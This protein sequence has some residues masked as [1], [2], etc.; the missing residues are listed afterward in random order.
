MKINIILALFL[1]YIQQISAQFVSVLEFPKGKKEVEIP[2]ELKNNFIVVNIIFNRILPLQ[3]IYDTGAEH[4]ILTQKELALLLG[5]PFERKINILG[6]DL[7]RELVAHIARR[8]PMQ[9]GDIKF[10]R[11]VLVFEE[12]YFEFDKYAGVQI[13]G[14]LGADVFHGYV[15]TLDY[16]R[17]KL[18]VTEGNAF[19]PPKSKH[20]EEVPFELIRNRPYLIAKITMPKDT[21]VEAK[22]LIDTGAALGLLLHLQTDKRFELPQKVITSKLGS[23]LGGIIEGVVGRVQR[24]SIGKSKLEQII[25]NFQD[26]PP[27]F[28]S[29]YLSGRKGLLGNDI[30][31][32][33]N[34]IMD[35][36]N[37]KMYIRRNKY[38]K[39]TF[40]YD[41]SGLAIV[42]GGKNTQIF[43]VF[44]VLPNSPA[45][46]A[47]ILR[48]DEI[49]ALNSFGA[50]WF[51]LLSLARKLQGKEN[52]K[53]KLKI[54]RNNLILR[55]EFRLKTLI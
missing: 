50:H 35:F 47:G 7:S 29:T 40:D 27:N 15:V 45:A 49:L 8:I 54:K 18:V 1:F 34:I 31:G 28:D 25:V 9:L 12:D 14:I 21:A 17:Q 46:E 5:I 26:L 39:A 38:F 4:S 36:K 55:K 44:D 2:F 10:F 53:I 32:R 42:A 33:F 37:V 19:R 52:K 22:L 23:G 43:T 13:N 51:T 24:F 30:L 6:S 20:W 48:G 16:E 41:K 11:D 3:F